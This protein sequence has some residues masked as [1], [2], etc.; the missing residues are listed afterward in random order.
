MSDNQSI[1]CYPDFT[2]IDRS[3]F[4]DMYPAFNLLKD[5]ISEFTFANLYL[6]RHVYGYRVARLPEGGLVI[7]G[8]RDGKS[9]FYLPCCIP[10]VRH[11][12]HLMA[13]H[14]YM[15]HF[16]ESQSVQHRIELES[17]GYL[18]TEDR[19]HFDYL[20]NRKDLAELTGK[21]YHKKRNLVNGFISNYECTQKPLKRENVPDALAVLEEWRSA[22]G[23]DGDYQAA[24]EGLELFEELGMRGAVYYIEDKPVGWCLG[25][26]LA[27][28]TMF[29]IHFE[30]ACDRFKGIYQFINQAFAQ[31]LPAHYRLIN[32]E[33]DLGNEGLRQAKMTYRPSGFVRKYRIIHPE[34]A[35]FTPREVQ[36]PAEC[37][38]GTLHED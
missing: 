34:G 10:P 8:S 12:D 16:S 15:K 3:M 30:K 35:A 17:R 11:F 9:F 19:D 25:E 2:P 38:P 26:S 7:S 33:Q 24:R 14:D 27:K 28:G 31:S 18:V 29:A 5:G 21:E 6:F 1:P 13:S 36:E 20:Y 37:G 32:R 22:K 23:Y 4:S